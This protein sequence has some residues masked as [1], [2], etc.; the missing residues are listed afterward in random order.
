MLSS[1]APSPFVTT[2]WLAD[3]LHDPGLVVVDGSWYL[4]AM[5]R[6][7]RA[8]YEAGHIPGAV[9]FDIE[10]IADL[11]AG[12]PHMLPS[13]A[14][15]AAAVGA[16]GISDAMR[17][18]V[19]DGAGLFSA[20]R[21]RWTLRAFGAKDVSILAGGLPQWIAEGRSLTSGRSVGRPDAVFH[22]VLDPAAVIAVPEVQAALAEGSTQIV[23]ARPA[24]RFRGEVPEPRPGLRAGH[25]PGSRNIPFDKLVT[26]GRLLSPEM[27]EACFAE[28]GV[29]P[30]RPVVATCGS[31]IS[32]A[33]LSLALESTGHRPA[34][35]YDGSWAEWGGRPDL[36]VATGDGGPPKDPDPD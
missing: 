14:D 30:A 16:L 23:D 2:S 5:G 29:D 32:A 18:V 13:A 28:A 20:P 10:V 25:I 34:C 4:P 33:I 11:R 26:A 1:T 19:Y 31:G 15:F 7:P 17:I 27:L 22:A 35:I 3:H 12:L 6:D 24:A 8:D 9:F 21:V 36:P